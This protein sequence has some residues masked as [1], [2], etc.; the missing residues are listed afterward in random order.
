[1]QGN[2]N[3][4]SKSTARKERNARP[5]RGEQQEPVQQ[6]KR[7]KQWERMDTKRQWDNF[8]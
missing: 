2:S 4:E 6:A 3:F 1:M 8:Q 7:G 5:P